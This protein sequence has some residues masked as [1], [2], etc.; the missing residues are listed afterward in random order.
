MEYKLGVI[1]GMGPQATSVFFQKVIE[2]T[3]AHKD[4]DHINMVILNHSTLPDRTSVIL[5]Q[6]EEEFFEYI[7]N[8]IKL[9]E[10]LG[11]KNIA[12]PCNTS[13]FFYRE[14]HETTNVPI[15]NMVEETVKKIHELGGNQSK[16][17]ILATRGTIES[18]IY[19]KECEKYG[20]NLHTP[21][22]VIQQ[23]VMDIIYN[24]VKGELDT[25]SCE[26]EEI[27]LDLIYQE[28]CNCVILAC[29]EL[30]CFKLNE[31]VLPYC[32]DAMDVL[33]EKT[34][35]LSGKKLKKKFNYGVLST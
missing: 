1:G 32:I 2:N 10:S 20:L 13:H 29:T 28:G 12:I 35:I 19:K 27:I 5:N 18:G 31:N 16:V 8:D 9:L 24:D 7:F 14:L 30:S 33:V 15:I 23:K 6:K 4:Q 22:E 25:G 26:L 11:V 21:N 3:E 17:G 34:I